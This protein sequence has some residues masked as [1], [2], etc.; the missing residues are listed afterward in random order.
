MEGKMYKI[1][2]VCCV[3]FFSF[4][5]GL[6]AQSDLNSLYE[7]A[8]TYSEL[9]YKT[10][11]ADSISQEAVLRAKASLDDDIVYES[12]MAYLTRDQF[13]YLSN[14]P[15]KFLNMAVKLAD[16]TVDPQKKFDLWILL[17]RQ[18]LHQ[19]QTVKGSEFARRAISY[20]AS[21]TNPAIKARA[22]IASAKSARAN[23]QTKEAWQNLLNAQ[24]FVE[25]VG[26]ANKLNIQQNLDDELIEF[27]RS[28]NDF[29]KAQSLVQQKMQNILSGSPVD[30]TEYMWTLF[31]LCVLIKE[32]APD[33]RIDAKISSLIQFSRRHNNKTLLGYTD[34]L[35]RNYLIN[36]FKLSEFYNQYSDEYNLSRLE[37][38]PEKTAEFCL[39]NALFCEYRNNI[40]SAKLLYERVLKA[41][42]NL[43]HE[44]RQANYHKRYGEFL[45]RHGLKEEA[46]V[47]LQEAMRLAQ[48]NNYISYILNVVDPLDSL[49]RSF[50]DYESAYRFSDIKA[51]AKAFVSS[52]QM[53]ENLLIMELENDKKQHEIR[54]H[55]EY[56]EQK[57]KHNLQ[58][59]AIAIGLISL[60]L[61][62]VI[63]SSMAV[64]EWLIEMLGFFSILFIFE[65]VILILDHKIHHW[66]HGGPVKIFLVKIAILSILFPL[67]HV[68]EHGVTSY[69][70]KNKLLKRPKS[71]FFRRAMGKLY[72]W[73][74]NDGENGH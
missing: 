61:L 45:Y 22:Y 54:Q 38:A 51:K 59:F 73:M 13:G 55:E 3:C 44:Y 57:K 11:K 12:L 35:N 6:N 1:A 26:G 14:I 39:S 70:K 40:D 67:H 8:K 17:S 24:N 18:L 27:H 33:I 23:N 62:L 56:E 4:F 72:P 60:F 58:Y 48:K 34:A 64:P 66:A 36:N 20:A 7:A 9:E 5:A 28:I 43:N 71:G 65:F 37:S 19:Q 21:T 63:V 74:D 68:I 30:S 53:K 31:N 25:K 10:D 69:M 41:A 29:D 15:E 42:E 50:N 16:E 32:H 46:Y 2:L 47:Q 49:A 52:Q